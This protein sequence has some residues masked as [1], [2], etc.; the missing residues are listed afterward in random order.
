MLHRAGVPGLESYVK[1]D[2]AAVR[3]E[4][5]HREK[6]SVHRDHES[7]FWLLQNCVQPGMQLHQVEEALGEPGEFTTEQNLAKSDGLHQTT[8]SAYR[9]G[10]DNKGQSVILFFRDDRLSNFNADDYRTQSKDRF[11]KL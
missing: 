9:W 2:P 5:S 3:K 6:F 10:P 4:Q 1:K 8:D 7:L 11:G